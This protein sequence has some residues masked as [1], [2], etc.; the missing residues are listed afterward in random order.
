M[1][2]YKEFIKKV[3]ID[4]DAITF[5]LRPGTTAE[6]AREI[7]SP[8]YLEVKQL[9]RNSRS[10]KLKAQV[11]SKAIKFTMNNVA[12]RGAVSLHDLEFLAEKF[13]LNDQQLRKAVKFLNEGDR[14]V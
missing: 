1:F 7:M 8:L 10:L 13:G 6:Q 11:S 3:D 9:F 4:N 5:T 12:Q 2:S 14:G